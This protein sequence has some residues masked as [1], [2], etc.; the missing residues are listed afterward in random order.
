[1]RLTW[2]SETVPTPVHSLYTVS[3]GKDIGIPQRVSF[4]PLTYDP[5]VVVYHNIM[6]RVLFNHYSGFEG[7]TSIQKR[8]KSMGEVSVYLEEGETRVL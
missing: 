1:M 7:E 3:P 5:S 4:L 2:S 8:R 6:R